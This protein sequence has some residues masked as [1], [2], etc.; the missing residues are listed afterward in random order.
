VADFSAGLGKSIRGL[1]VGIPCELMEHPLEP[2]VQAAFNAAQ[3]TFADP[4][5]W[6]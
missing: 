4:P 5:G 3:V 6:F 2:A 1:K